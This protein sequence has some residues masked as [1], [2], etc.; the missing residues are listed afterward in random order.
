MDGLS[1]FAPGPLA[2]PRACSRRPQCLLRL[3]PPAPGPHARRRDRAHRRRRSH[4]A[5]AHGRPRAFLAAAVSMRLAAALL[6]SLSMASFAAQEPAAP[7]GKTLRI[8]QQSIGG[9][10]IDPAQLSSIL[11]ANII[12]NVMEP[13]LRYDYVERPLRLVANT[14]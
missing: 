4:G 8:A 3:R 7:L 14:L 2:G 1:A 12:E 11:V 6:A 5:R 10:A 9:E 13:M